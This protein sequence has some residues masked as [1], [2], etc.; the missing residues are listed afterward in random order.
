MP[1]PPGLGLT[2][3]IKGHR[4]P[5]NSND[6]EE[7]KK[8]SPKPIYTGKLEPGEGLEP[9]SFL[10]GTQ[11]SYIYYVTKDGDHHK[12]RKVVANQ[13]FTQVAYPNAKKEKVIYD[14]LHTLEGWEDHVLPYVGGEDT[15]G[16]VIIDFK[17]M[18]GN[19]L[20]TYINKKRPSDEKRVELL[21]QAQAALDFCHEHE[22]THGDIKAENFYV[23]EGGKRCYIF[24]FGS[25]SMRPTASD[26]RRDEEAFKDMEKEV[27]SAAKGGGRRSKGTRRSKRSRR[28]RKTRRT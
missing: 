6:E 18:E 23:S 1:P 7:P 22:I 24:D 28:A 27:R 13:G 17:Y 25:G 20:L 14:K 19:D 12:V 26:F 4:S 10:V 21:N 3:S 9:I 11:N 16:S 2:L 5:P 15:Q 8:A